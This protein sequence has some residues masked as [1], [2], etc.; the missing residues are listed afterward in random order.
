MNLL[1]TK[2]QLTAATKATLVE[3]AL[4][5]Q[6]LAAD[7]QDTINAIENAINEFVAGKLGNNLKPKKF[8]WWAVLNVQSVISLVKTIIQLIKD[9]KDKYESDTAGR[10]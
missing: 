3:Q 6:Q 10:N 5:A 8:L 4:Y 9:L 2:E 7:R 1:T